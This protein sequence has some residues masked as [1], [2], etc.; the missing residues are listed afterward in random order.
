[1]A[2]LAAS[3]AAQQSAAVKMPPRRRETREVWDLRSQDVTL[4][5]GSV[6]IVPIKP[7]VLAGAA[8]GITGSNSSNP[9]AV[10]NHE[11]H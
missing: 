1:M 9:R 10:R 3:K 5:L 7:M 6:T 2:L 11:A 8:G 4:D